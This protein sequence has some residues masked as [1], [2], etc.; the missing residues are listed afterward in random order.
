MPEAPVISEQCV[1]FSPSLKP[2]SLLRFELYKT[3][4]RRCKALS[5]W[6]GPSY[7]EHLWF[8][9]PALALVSS[10]WINSR[11]DAKPWTTNLFQHA[12]VN[13]ARQAVFL[14]IKFGVPVLLLMGVSCGG[15]VGLRWSIV[16]MLPNEARVSRYSGDLFLRKCFVW[17][18]FPG[19]FRFEN[20]SAQEEMGG[21]A[22]TGDHALSST[23]A[24]FCCW[25]DSGQKWP[26]AASPC[27]L[28]SQATHLIYRVEFIQDLHQIILELLADF[29][30][31]QRKRNE[32]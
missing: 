2:A 25:H 9:F 7:S 12:C 15:E 16:I 18:F 21:G 13:G 14:A 27:L 30:T 11:T 29:F 3:S 5:A 19:S 6:T 24:Q 28:K 20:E 17:G 22:P 4:G 23:S 26:N 10:R 31:L 32:G 1:F 8:C